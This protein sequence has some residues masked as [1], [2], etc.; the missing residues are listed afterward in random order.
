M[1]KINELIELIQNIE[2]SQIINIIIAIVIVIFTVILSPLIS[3]IISKI[4]NWKKS[5]EQIKEGILYNCLKSLIIVGGIYVATLIIGFSK[6]IDE[7][8]QKIYRLSIVWIIAK[9]TADA[10]TKGK[11]LK[12]KLK[13]KENDPVINII[14]KTIKVFLYIF[15]GYLSFKEFGFDLGSLLTGLGL[16]TAIIALA[17]Q[18]TFRDIF[19]GLSI[20]WDKPFAIGDYVEIGTTVKTISGTVEEISFRSTKLRTPEDAIVTIQ[21]SNISTQNIINWSVIKKRVYKTNLK[22]PLETDEA[23][24]EKIINRIKFI[25]KY[26]KDIIKES[27]NVYF[28]TIDAD[29][30]NINVYVE[31]KIVNYAEYQK[32]CNKLNLIMLNILETQQVK[33]AYPGQNIYI[34][35][36]E[37]EYNETKPV[38]MHSKAVKIEK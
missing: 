20:F 23:T 22:L 17:A 5:K 14:N 28:N 13:G 12:S 3:Y 4:F 35:S 15:A 31:T 38:K 30:V 25:L 8:I 37:K 36:F 21:N 2:L 33:L 10:L 11:I 26:N 1:E 27:T 16:S 24:I 6:E 7:F 19:S 29:G 34:K 32:L 9:T 18:D